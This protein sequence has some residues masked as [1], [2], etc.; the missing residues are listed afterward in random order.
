VAVLPWRAAFWIFGSV[1]VVW[2]AVWYAWYRDVTPEPT[3]TGP[4]IGGAGATGQP[5]HDKIPWRRLFAARQL[6]LIMAMYAF[7]VWG[8]TFYLTWLH[9]YLVKGRGFSESEMAPL[10]TLPFVLGAL[11]NPLGG[12]LSD[13]LSR[14]LGVKAG[15]RLMG[16]TCLG[17]ASLFLLATALTTGK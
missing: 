17:V 15:R 5:P 9:T 2:A 4:Q 11:A 14:R 8:S 3:A 10:S 6:W 1:G 7:Y 12:F 13:L 16:T